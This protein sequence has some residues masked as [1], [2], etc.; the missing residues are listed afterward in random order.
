MT[1]YH[2]LV[3]GNN[4]SEE[5]FQLDTTDLSKIKERIVV[6]YLKGESFFF[7]GRFLDRSKVKNIVIKRSDCTA[8]EYANMW[9]REHP[10]NDHRLPKEA[11]VWDDTSCTQDIFG[12]ICEE[13]EDLIEEILNKPKAPMDK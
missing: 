12:Q 2:V 1:Y 10:N 6:P 9:N 7:D 8:Q 4:P 11:I 13:Y 3:E 5:Y